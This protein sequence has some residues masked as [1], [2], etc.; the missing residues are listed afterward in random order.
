VTSVSPRVR[1]EAAISISACANVCLCAREGRGAWPQ[2]SHR[3]IHGDQLRRW[4]REQPFEPLLQRS[5]SRAFQTLDAERQLLQ[6]HGGNGEARVVAEL[7]EHARVGTSADRLR[8]DVRVHEH[9]S[10]RSKR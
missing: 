1:A 2:R 7:P 9:D 3:D 6:R 10:A 5:A 4:I 8:D